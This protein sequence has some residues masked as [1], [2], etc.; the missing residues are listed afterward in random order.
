[1][2]A[3]CGIAEFQC[4]ENRNLETALILEINVEWTT[5]SK[6]ERNMFVRAVRTKGRRVTTL[7]VRCI[8]TPTKMTEMNHLREEDTWMTRE[9]DIGSS[10]ICNLEEEKIPLRVT[11]NTSFPVR[12]LIVKSLYLIFVDIWAMMQQSDPTPMQ[13]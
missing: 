9:T 12:R 7:H 2:S 13:M 3:R 6:T 11:R 5:G 8:A 4:R 10:S 1:M